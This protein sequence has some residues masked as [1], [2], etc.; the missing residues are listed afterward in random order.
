MSNNNNS[1]VHLLQQ[2][3]LMI[4]P[5]CY[6]MLLFITVM[7]FHTTLRHNRHNKYQTTATIARN[8][9]VNHGVISTLITIENPSYPS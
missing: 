1:D 8:R 5:V 2:C 4:K 7:S 3:Q 9:E 6:Q